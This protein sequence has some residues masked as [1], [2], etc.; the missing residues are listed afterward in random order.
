MYTVAL[1]KKHI[2]KVMF[3]SSLVNSVIRQLGLKYWLSLKV[4]FPCRLLSWSLS[5]FL[6]SG[7]SPAASWALAEE[8]VK[9]EILFS[10]PLPEEIRHPPPPR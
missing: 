3:K 6:L 5:G 2:Q 7:A 10:L 9:R 8:G 1:R 4:S